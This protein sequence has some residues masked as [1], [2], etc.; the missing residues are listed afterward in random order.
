MKNPRFSAKNILTIPNLIS[1]FRILLIPLIIWLYCGKKQYTA[2][3]AVIVISGASDIIDGKIARKF[4]MV[5]DV[6]KVLDPIADK[7]TQVTLVICLTARYPWMWALL[8]LFAVKECLM[9]LWGYLTLKIT[10]TIHSAK[11][12]GKLSTVV[13]YAVMMILILFV[14]IPEA[15]AEALMLLCGGIILLSLVMYGRFY[16]AILDQAPS[17]SQQQKTLRTARNVVLG[18]IWVGIIVICF[19]H[20]KE[21]SAEEIARYTPGNPWL[22]GI[23]MLA[24]FALKS[25]SIVIYSG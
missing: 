19:L 3:I 22:A 9:L 15:G 25:L 5:S 21:L 14:D 11:W 13:L 8:A 24:L 10:D 1:L 23:V 6:G 17:G 16:H 18:L 7:L 20:R 12:Y 2:T 4:H